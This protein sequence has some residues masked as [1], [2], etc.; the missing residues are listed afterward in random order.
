MKKV[1]VL[2]VLIVGVFFA[3]HVGYRSV[4]VV[5]EQQMGA[6]NEVDAQQAMQT[7]RTIFNNVWDKAN[8]RLMTTPGVGAQGVFETTETIMNNVWD[9]AFPLLPE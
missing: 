7:V 2:L 6:L 3:L 1:L 8:Q 4:N 5:E 9:Q